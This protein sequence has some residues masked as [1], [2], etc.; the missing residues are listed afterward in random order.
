MRDQVCVS[1]SISCQVAQSTGRPFGCDRSRDSDLTDE[2]FLIAI[3]FFFGFQAHNLIFYDPR[4]SSHRFF[5]S[6][7]NE[8]NNDGWITSCCISW[9]SIRLKCYRM[10]F[11]WFIFSFHL[12]ASFFFFSFKYSNH[13]MQS[14]RYLYSRQAVCVSAFKC[15]TCIFNVRRMINPLN[16]YENVA[17][18]IPLQFRYVKKSNSQRTVRSR[19]AAEQTLFL[20]TY[21]WIMCAQMHSI[22]QCSMFAF[23]IYSTY[24]YW[25]SFEMH[26]LNWRV[27]FCP[28]V[29]TS[30]TASTMDGRNIELKWNEAP[31]SRYAQRISRVCRRRRFI[32]RYIFLH[33]KLQ[34]KSLAFSLYLGNALKLRVAISFDCSLSKRKFC[35]INFRLFHQH[36]KYIYCVSC[37]LVLTHGTFFLFVFSVRQLL[38]SHMNEYNGFCAMKMPCKIWANRHKSRFM[39]RFVIWNDILA[40]NFQVNK[41]RMKHICRCNHCME[42]P[43][44]VN[45][46]RLQSHLTSIFSAIF[47]LHSNKSFLYHSPNIFPMFKRNDQNEWKK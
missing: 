12:F 28:S 5:P 44:K 21:F 25:Q 13:S 41:G 22:K 18:R 45:R 46:V 19:A 7:Q 17:H 34:Q 38:H 31:A 20:H 33:A 47:S 29:N 30:R 9:V 14:N 40:T 1:L 36:Q 4:K 35:L 16:R 27:A 3:F 23:V 24:K 6:R 11:W 26:A 39:Q 42:T 10:T 43:I 15:S 32:Y 2:R 37:V 8:I